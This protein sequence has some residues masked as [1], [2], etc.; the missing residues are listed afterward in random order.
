MVNNKSHAE[1]GHDVAGTKTSV[2]NQRGPF[3]TD[4][5]AYLVEALCSFEGQIET[6]R[7]SICFLLFKSYLNAEDLFVVGVGRCAWQ[8]LRES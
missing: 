7:L 4:Y 6:N 5:K 8:A 3:T 2:A 1:I